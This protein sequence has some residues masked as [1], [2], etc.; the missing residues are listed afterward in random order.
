VDAPDWLLV[1]L[2]VLDG[3]QLAAA[4]VA[5]VHAGRRRRAE[6]SVLARYS[7]DHGL[8]LAAGAVLL[9]VPLL[10]G[11]ADVISPRTA[12]WIVVLAEVA[13]AVAARFLLDRFD[14]RAA[15]G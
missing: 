6:E 9:A 2:L 3:V 5:W 11:L 10:L 7:R 8:L 1:A 12:V 14:R 15:A 4:L 13:G